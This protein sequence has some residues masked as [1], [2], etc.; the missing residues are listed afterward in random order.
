MN[1][2]SQFN[3]VNDHLMPCGQNIEIHFMRFGY[4]WK[5]NKFYRVWG[6]QVCNLQ[7]LIFVV[8]LFLRN[9]SQ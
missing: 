4:V 1:N 7:Y 8:N 9:I 3:C 5:Y 2:Y 6:T